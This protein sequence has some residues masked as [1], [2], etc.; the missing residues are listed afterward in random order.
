MSNQS[1]LFPPRRAPYFPK[2]EHTHLVWSYSR[3]ESVQRCHAQYY[4][5]YFGSHK[6][7]A[8]SDRD[9]AQLTHLKKLKNRHLRSGE[10]LHLGISGYLRG[11]KRG[12]IQTEQEVKE[13]ALELFDKDVTYSRR[14]AAGELVPFDPNP[15]IHLLEYF[16]G[17]TDADENCAEAR[18]KLE[19]AITNFFRHPDFAHFHE[20]RLL[21]D[22]IIEET[23]RSKGSPKFEGRIDFAYFD[24]ETL[25]IVDWKTSEP[26]NAEDSLQLFSYALLAHRNLGTP[27]DQIR[28]ERAHLADAIVESMA[29]NERDVR[30]SEYRI[31]QD[32]EYMRFLEGLGNEGRRDVFHP[33]ASVKLCELCPFQKVCL[34]GKS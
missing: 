33:K 21:R 2:N 22:A 1:S 34:R 23:F 14:H 28:L 10:I 25:V 24:Q 15:A 19:L 13:R 20:A 3:G 18:S 5:A 4:F 9:K 8:L 26:E 30:R 29:I 11:L 31:I 17:Q 6:E 16:Y 12:E 32:L 27:L 7:K